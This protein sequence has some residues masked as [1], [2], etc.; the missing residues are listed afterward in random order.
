MNLHYGDN[1]PA[2]NGWAPGDYE[3]RCRECGKQ[4]T[5]DKRAWQCANCAYKER[6]R[7]LDLI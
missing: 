1:S 2:K 5:G 6:R 3:C 4:F 7:K